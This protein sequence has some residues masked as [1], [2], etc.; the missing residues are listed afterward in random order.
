MSSEWT[1]PEMRFISPK[2][3]TQTRYR[4][5][6]IIN[7]IRTRMNKA[8]DRLQL[9]NAIRLLIGGWLFDENDVLEIT[10]ILRELADDYQE[11]ID[12]IKN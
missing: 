10:S 12:K 7:S 11:E 8:I 4:C 1:R 9:K 5:S 3:H 2:T 6:D